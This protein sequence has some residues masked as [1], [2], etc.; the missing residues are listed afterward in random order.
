MNESC[1]RFRASISEVMGLVALAALACIWP[2]FIPTEVLV[3]L[4][5][6]PA[7]GGPLAARARLISL[8]VVL[9]AVY[10]YPLANFL[11]SP[12]SVR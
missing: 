6:V 2:G 7:R 1:P 12:I 11:I 4:V 3:V 8:A 9:A 5:W 10:L